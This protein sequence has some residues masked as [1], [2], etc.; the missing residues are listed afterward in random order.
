MTRIGKTIS[1]LALSLALGLGAGSAW[2]QQ[3]QTE[4]LILLADSVYLQGNN[5][6]TAAGSVEILKG[7][8]KLKASKVIY[9]SRND[10]IEIEGPIEITDGDSIQIFSDF[11]EL[12]T[13]LQTGIL[14]S[15]RFVL[16]QQVEI[17][18][19]RIQ[20]LGQGQS[21]MS[22]VRATSCKTCDDGKPPLWQIRA[23]EVR[24]DQIEKQLYFDNV[25]FRFLDVPVFYFPHLRLPDPSL[26]RSRGFLAPSIR[27]RSRLATGFKLPYFIPIGDH[28]DI[29]VTPYFSA[30]TR[31][32]ELRY[33]QAFA[34]GSIELKG[35]ITRDDL[36]LNKVRGYL[37]GTGEF[38]IRRGYKLTFDIKSVTDDSYLSDY[39]YA[40]YSRLDSEVGLAR[41]T[42]QENTA[43]T[44]YKFES[45][46]V[47][48]PNS[49]L[50]TAVLSARKEKRTIPSI[51]GEFYWQLEAHGH[52]RSSTVDTDLDGD[53]VVDGRDVF[54]INAE[55]QW[56]KNWLTVSGL[57][58][59][60]TANAAMDAIGTN[61]DA[62]ISD[63]N[64][65]QVTPA[66][67]ATLRYP[68][69]RTTVSGVSHIL[70][71]IIQFGY[72]GGDARFGTTNTIANDESTRVEFDEGNLLSLS[73]FPSD[74]RRERG[75][76]AAWGLN[77]SRYGDQ[78]TSHLSLGQ[79][80]RD[81]R[82]TDFSR[83]S[84]LDN[85]ESNFL[86]AAQLAHEDGFAL[87]ARALVHGL[88]G[89][90]KAEARGSWERQDFG[91]DFTYV[92]LDADAAED[93][94]TDVSEWNLDGRYRLS[95]HWTGLANWRYDIA[96]S[97]TAEAGVG[98]EYQNECLKA[99]FAVS[100]RFTSSASVQP[101]TDLSF[102]VE[103]L[104]FSTNTVDK[105]YSRS[106]KDSAG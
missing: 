53:G 102:T 55:A 90:N 74:D 89:L 71:P 36:G 29:T 16:Q 78:L 54:R 45:L 14:E 13:N 79:V 2:S 64:Y 92:W 91:L 11:A 77:W 104:G 101:S 34:H 1:S 75:A 86:V 82:H 17:E 32:V 85:L 39:G 65:V 62:T 69:Q 94:A 103:I 35:A 106:C 26:K 72:I 40:D 52:Y 97:D 98:L 24:H 22:Q 7:Q 47:A 30:K 6:L 8:V 67:A 12:D 84:G 59:G 95:K 61:D 18:A 46:N 105:S 27:T 3:N 80:V 49:K 9:D 66:V 73:R 87:S 44:L 15:A 70:E 57:E 38:D 23:S 10:R 50:P 83:S 60:L 100:R 81:D 58:F 31:T 20:R 33:R 63:T 42:R 5:F 99:E 51:G 93:R 56:R 76:V 41:T 48:E 28:K 96:A 19:K 37:F 4:N 21:R 43:I 25:Q 88:D 68:L